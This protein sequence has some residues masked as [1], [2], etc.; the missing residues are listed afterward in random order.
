MF[1]AAKYGNRKA[2]KVFVLRNPKLPDIPN[3]KGYLPIHVAA[4]SGHMETVQYLLRVTRSPLDD[5]R[6]VQLLC[7]LINSGLYGKCNI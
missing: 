2:A 6:G 3:E 1:R 4:T 5:D 7:N